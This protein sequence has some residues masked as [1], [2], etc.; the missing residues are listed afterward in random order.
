MLS[1]ICSY[2]NFGE[3]VKIRENYIKFRKYFPHPITTVEVAL[4]DQKFFIDDSIKIR[5]NPSNI[6][7]QKERCLNIAIESL[8]D[9][10][11]SIAWIDPDI[12]FLNRNFKQDTEKALEK[13][14]VVHMFDRCIEEPK[15]NAVNNN[16]SLGYKLIHDMDVKFPHIGYAWAFRREVLIED[17]LY[18]LDPVGNS[19]VL[20]LLT[21]RGV[22]NHKTILD[23]QLPYRQEFLSWA[24]D[25]YDSVQSDIGYSPGIVKHFYHGHYGHRMY[26]SRNNL[27][28]DTSFVP[29]KHL[30]IDTN[31]LYKII[32]NDK[33]QKLIKDYFKHR[34]KYET[35]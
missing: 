10:V 9:S 35:V 5:A 28:S 17:K 26:I 18:D 22:W 13:Y 12:K 7:W 27:L 3:S 31:N 23:L 1:F 19:D 29:S 34:T 11:D 21:W 20:Q 33:L 6:L 14:K 8:P 4:S 30:R 2:F 15:I 25:S 24:W 16:I 32:N